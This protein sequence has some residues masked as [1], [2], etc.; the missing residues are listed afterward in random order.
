[1]IEIPQEIKKVLR[2]IG[3]DRT[4]SQVYVALLKKSLLGIQDISNELKLPRSSVHLACESLVDKGIVKITKLGKRRTFYIEHP[5]DI[6]NFLVQQENSISSKKNSLN[7]I[8]PRLIATYA[9]SQ[10]SEPIDIEELQGE[11]GLVE[12]FYRSLDQPKNGEVLRFGADPAMFTVARNRLV[13]Y[14]EERMK[15][16][17]YTRLLLT[18][19]EYSKEEIKDARFKMREA[20]ILPKEVYNPNTQTSVWADNVTITIWDKGLHSIIIKNK[21]IAEF[22]KQ[23]FEIAWSQA[24]KD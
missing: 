6:G 8:L 4:E 20:R 22:M 13:E 7:E 24:R 16:K 3:L 15:K 14:R 19:S 11:D 2:E 23:M 17:I 1:M 9:T 21:A 18:E 10:E 12:I 5:K